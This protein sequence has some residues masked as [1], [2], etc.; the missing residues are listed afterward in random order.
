MSRPEKPQRPQR[1]ERPPKRDMLA[2]RMKKKDE[3]YR[4]RNPVP[5]PLLV[6][7]RTGNAETDSEA[8]HDAYQN[9]VGSLSNRMKAEDRRM[10]LATDSEFYCVVCFQ[11]RAQKEY[12]LRQTG[13]D[14]YGD[15]YLDGYYVAEKMGVKFPETD[16]LNPEDPLVEAADDVDV[17]YN[18]SDKVDKELL[19]LVREDV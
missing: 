1:R 9:S 4:R 14:A 15:K 5:N 16:E 6:N 17:P 12:F 2:D 10:R 11:T 7:E 3:A 8:Y 18:K 13:W 19:M